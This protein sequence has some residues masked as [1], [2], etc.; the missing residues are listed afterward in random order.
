MKII[1]FAYILLI[2]LSILISIYFL[3][4]KFFYVDVVFYSAL[5]DVF[6]ATIIIIVI[7]WFKNNFTI[8]SFFE[9]FQI[10][11]ICFLIGYSLS[12]SVPT[13][14]DRS[15]SFYILEKIQEK[16]GSIKRSSF[17]ELFV[18]EYMEDHQ[19][20]KI[21]ITEQ[22]ES[23]TIIIENNCVKITKLGEMLSSFSKFFRKNF[24]SDKRLLDGEYTNRLV[25]N[26]NF[27]SQDKIDEVYK[28]D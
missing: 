10:S 1:K 18:N 7:L 4:I 5:I 20:I 22:L 21:R 15:L 17:Q 9:K 27:N 26:Q 24:L 16:G 3:H 2:F 8:F 23:G 19:L 25:N 28:C 11:V 14:I 13:L 12:I 6:F